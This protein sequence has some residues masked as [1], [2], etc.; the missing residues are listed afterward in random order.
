MRF[1]LRTLLLMFPAL[2][3]SYALAYGCASRM[4]TRHTVGPTVWSE[5]RKSL[6]LIQSN[7]FHS[8]AAFGA[9]NASHA[10]LVNKW[11]RGE[12]NQLPQN[13]KRIGLETLDRQDIWGKP[14]CCVLLQDESPYNPGSLIRYLGFYSCGEDGLSQSAGND[15]DDL[16]SWNRMS[17]D[18]Y[19]QRQLEK[20]R[21]R[22]YWEALW[23]LPFTGGFLIA[24][25]LFIKN[26]FR[27]PEDDEYPP[28]PAANADSPS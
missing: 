10:Q 22:V 4:Q 14:F 17:G 26:L 20:E 23:L 28:T 24:C 6:N 8:Q 16:N 13:L 2:I 3:V 21:K 11:F 1:S 25:W 7:S 19:F 15:P 18:I 5:S 9:S 12:I 27:L